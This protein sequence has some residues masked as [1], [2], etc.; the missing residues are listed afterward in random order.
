MYSKVTWLKQITNYTLVIFFNVSPQFL[1][2]LLHPPL[3]RLSL[4]PSLLILIRD[5]SVHVVKVL[6]AGRVLSTGMTSHV[7]SN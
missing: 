6:L 7:Y 1:L 5:P 2:L 4:S 3:Q